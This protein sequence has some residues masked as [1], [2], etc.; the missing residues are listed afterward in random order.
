MLSERKKDLTLD[1]VRIRFFCFAF[2]IFLA[3]FLDVRNTNGSRYGWCHLQVGSAQHVWCDK[4][5]CRN[6]NSLCMGP[7]GNVFGLGPYI[8]FVRS[9]NRSGNAPPTFIKKIIQ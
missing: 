5:A 6:E 8:F 1:S 7:T 2:F 4:T 3:L 9:T